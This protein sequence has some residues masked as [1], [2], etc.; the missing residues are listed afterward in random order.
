MQPS[1]LFPLTL[2]IPTFVCGTVGVY[3]WRR[4]AMPAALP[5]AIVM[6][7]VA[8]W[9][10]TYGIELTTVTLSAQMF[11][12]DV[13][14]IGIV[15]IPVAWFVFCLQYAGYGT[16]LTCRRLLALCAMPV[17]TLLALW[18]NNL[19]GLVY[20][21]V[22]PVNYGWL[23]TWE[24]VH[25]P[26][27]YLNAAYGYAL[28]A[29]GIVILLRTM[30]HA[31][32]RQRVQSLVI[33][34]AA[35]VPWISNI[36]YMGGLGPE[37]GLDLTPYGFVITGLA[38][39]WGLF[40]LGLLDVIPLA[41]DALFDAVRDGVLVL[42][43]DDRIVDT[44]TG[45]CAM[46]A[47][48]RAQLLGHTAGELL[49]CWQQLLDTAERPAEPELI[50]GWDIRGERRQY[51]LR[52]FG[53]PVPQGQQHGHL[54]FIRD[55][56]E[57]EAA[58]RELRDSEVSY[59][60]LFDA[61]DE[62]V[63]V[64]DATGRF[65]DV[66]RGAEQM[67]GYSR[68]FFMGKTPEILSAPG[69]NDLPRLAGSIE[70]ALAGRPQ[71]FEFWGR[72][73]NGEIF[74]KD[75]RLYKG[76]Y[77][78]ADAVIALAVDT[79]DRTRVEEAQRMAAVG[80][81]AAGVAHEFNN[82]LAAMLL[83]AELLSPVDCPEARELVDVVQRSARRGGET[84]SNLMA[85]ARPRQLE[86]AE[87][88]IH[89]PIEAALI[90]AHR[91]IENAQV[92]VAQGDQASGACVRG[93]AGQLEQVFLNLF[94]NA[95]YAMD[96]PQV[97]TD[98]RTLTVRT[99]ILGVEPK[100]E[101]VVTVADSGVGIA[102]ENLTRI[103]EPFF[104][105]RASAVD[106]D[107]TGAG[108]GLSVSHG[109]IAAHGGRM[110]VA[111]VPGH[112]ATFTVRLPLSQTDA[113]AETTTTAPAEPLLALRPLRVLIAEDEPDVRVAVAQALSLDGHHVTQAATTEE[114]MAALAANPFDAIITDL[115]LP[116]AG[117]EAI[118]RRA[119]GLDP[120]P[121]TLV[122]TGKLDPQLD[123]QLQAAGVDF[124]LRKP[125]SLVQVRRALAELVGPDQQ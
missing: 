70:G 5:F 117:G 99:E 38:L 24:A 40:R 62:A 88:A 69:K 63:Y 14:Y 82:L 32:R 6:A 108:L 16:A 103:F 56:T 116:G 54:L 59:R 23:V 75:V 95:C 46:L 115:M 29:T 113:E 73:S 41:R 7:A 105:T 81:L 80:Q 104:T 67:Y 64:Q 65:L 36:L 35:L 27:Y 51:E 74:P 15:T 49:P 110:E 97:L 109:I 94:I 31:S 4:R 66:N 111:S 121:V 10:L 90:V 119:K 52:L 13:E 47:R 84:C 89:R 22:T 83:R 17:L 96:E 9:S 48:G 122:I 2:M 8:W 93:D 45:A 19:H 101:V 11:W 72:R 21:S 120:A 57:A 124:Y 92:V 86:R 33:I 112:G 3:A 26:M 30:L 123:E 76:R 58:R 60:D 77:L 25:G 71:Q 114:A 100:Q 102:R 12:T 87:V 55:V 37:R 61:V 53:I 125:F 98:Q 106:T 43:E 1:Q 68:E 118:V 39:A 50:T 78:G 107:K 34:L 28:V 79:T 91:Q 42:D 44:N 20:A 18:T 85:F